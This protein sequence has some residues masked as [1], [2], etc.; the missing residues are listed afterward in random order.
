VARRPI[1]PSGDDA[2][3]PV[4]LVLLGFGTLVAVLFVMTAPAPVPQLALAS[5]TV[6]AVTRALRW[7]LRQDSWER[8]AA[9]S[10]RDEVHDG[11]EKLSA[12]LAPRPPK[13]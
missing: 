11:I 1:L 3:R 13:V 9:R 6:V 10:I 2:G 7:G 8:R 4:V 12:F 5:G